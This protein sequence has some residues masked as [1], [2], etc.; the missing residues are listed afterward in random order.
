MEGLVLYGTAGCHLCETAKKM[1]DCR[2]TPARIVDITENDDLFEKYRT[3][4]PV[5]ARPDALELCW[6]F[7]PAMIEA[8]LGS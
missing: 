1:L 3:S 8:F 2:G 6:P 5:L 7:D 4:I